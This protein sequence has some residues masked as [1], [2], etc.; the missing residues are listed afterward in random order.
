MCARVCVCVRACSIAD[1]TRASPWPEGGA[2]GVHCCHVSSVGIGAG[3]FVDALNYATQTTSTS[4]RSLPTHHH[5]RKPSPPPTSPPTNSS[6]CTACAT[7]SL[8]P[9]FVCLLD[10]SR[11]SLDLD[12]DL[13][14]CHRDRVVCKMQDLVAGECGA[15]NPMMDLVSHTAP[16]SSL[17]R[18]CCSIRAARVS[19]FHTTATRRSLYRT[20]TAPHVTQHRIASHHT[21]PRHDTLRHF[22]PQ[23]PSSHHFIASLSSTNLPVDCILSNSWPQVLATWR[24]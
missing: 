4:L 10:R 7:L 11:M 20:H 21:T 15:D 9:L 2:R 13:D 18:W 6:S 23:P 8:A 1:T 17:V 3:G 22:A 24:G 16:R 12:I 19:A 14:L 5:D